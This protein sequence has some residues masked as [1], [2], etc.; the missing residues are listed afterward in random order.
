MKQKSGHRKLE[1]RD[2]NRPDHPTND[3]EQHRKLLDLHVFTNNLESIRDNEKFTYFLAMG[4]R[5]Q[6]GTDHTHCVWEDELRIC[7][8][9]MAMEHAHDSLTC[10][11]NF[12]W[13]FGTNRFHCQWFTDESG[14]GLAGFRCCFWTGP[15]LCSLHVTLLSCAKKNGETYKSSTN[16]WM[17][18]SNLRN[19]MLQ[20]DGADVIAIKFPMRVACC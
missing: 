5:N 15:L 9:Y 4:N 17:I 3:V 2:G 20:V 13:C 1:D 11:C 10:R 16:G 19:F 6:Q 14:K 12:R 8:R 7:N 18:I